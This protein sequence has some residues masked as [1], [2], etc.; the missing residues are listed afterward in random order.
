[1]AGPVLNG[2]KL[3]AA[4]TLSHVLSEIKKD[5]IFLPGRAATVF[6]DHG[7]KLGFLSGLYNFSD[8]E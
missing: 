7:I 4:H 3:P 6:L 2:R 1:M 5:A 8:R